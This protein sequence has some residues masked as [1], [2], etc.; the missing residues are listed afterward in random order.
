MCVRTHENVPETHRKREEIMLILKTGDIFESSCNVLVNPVNTVGVMGKGLALEFKKRFP[1]T[2]EKYKLA[3][4]NG[5]FDIGKLMLCCE[6]GKRILLF[7]TKKD[8]RSSSK[9]EY[10][11]AG[12][13]KFSNIYEQK[14]IGSAAFPMLG[15]GLGGLNEGDVLELM[16]KYL[17]PLPIRIEIFL[18]KNTK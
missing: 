14:K 7:P 2:F 16:K 8:W 17:G 5:T 6:N 4:S 10:I 12:L 9:L 18:S 1:L 13:A 3:C 11:E 15:C